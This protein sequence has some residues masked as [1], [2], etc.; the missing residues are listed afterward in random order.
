MPTIAAR[1][2]LTAIWLILFSARHR[3]ISQREKDELGRLCNVLERG[4]PGRDVYNYTAREFCRLLKSSGLF[5]TGT[6]PQIEDLLEKV[7]AMK[8]MVG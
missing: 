2:S 6:D 4:I 8:M 5:E 1:Q 3:A 7:D